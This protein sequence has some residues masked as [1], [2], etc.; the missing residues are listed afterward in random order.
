M[1]RLATLTLEEVLPLITHVQGKA[2]LQNH[3]FGVSSL[4][5]QCFK[6]SVVCVKCGIKGSFFAVEKNHESDTS[7]HL[8]MYSIDGDGTEVLMTKDHIVPVSRGGEESL[9]NAQTMCCICNC[10]KSDS[11]LDDEMK[12]SIKRT[13]LKWR[14]QGMSEIDI[15]KRLQNKGCCQEIGFV[16]KGHDLITIILDSLV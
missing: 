10:E 7:P 8:N 2:E 5:L 6:R 13:L 9:K 12:K 16:P 3:R 4:R 15:W 14:R 1:I 11:Y